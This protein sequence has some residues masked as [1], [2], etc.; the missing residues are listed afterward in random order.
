MY[1]KSSYFRVRYPAVTLHGSDGVVP[2]KILDRREIGVGIQ[3]LCGH[4]MAK[5]VTGDFQVCSAG[6]IFHPFLDAA[7]GYGLSGERSFLY[8]KDLLH[9]VRGFH[10]E[11]FQESSM[12][13]V[14]DIDNPILGALAVLGERDSAFKI[15]AAEGKMGSFF[16]PQSASEHNHKYGSIPWLKV[17]EG[18]WDEKRT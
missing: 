10:P 4:R 6:I 9:C 13:V 12:G 15:N 1:P 3:H 7:D 16:H 2:Q 8:Q 17:L 14:A 5:M 11:V 18:F